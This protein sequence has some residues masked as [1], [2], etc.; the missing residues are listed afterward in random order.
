[1][2]RVGFN[3]ADDTDDADDVHEILIE[4]MMKMFFTYFVGSESE[5]ESES[6]PDDI[7]INLFFE[8]SY[9]DLNK[10][11]VSDLYQRK[12]PFPILKCPSDLI[13]HI[14]SFL[15]SNQIIESHILNKEMNQL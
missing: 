1:M 5:S 13:T 7:D 4:P 2:F 10:T 14:F 15:D 9:L 3:D 12:N 11:H 8:S 6:G